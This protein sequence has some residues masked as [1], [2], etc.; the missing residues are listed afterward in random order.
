MEQDNIGGYR[1]IYFSRHFLYPPPFP[2]VGGGKLGV[3]GVVIILKAR[4]VF[5]VSK[6]QPSEQGREPRTKSGDLE[7]PVVRASASA[8]QHSAG[9][10]AGEGERAAG[11]SPGKDPLPSLGTLQA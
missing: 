10:Q 7:Q 11:E 6:A 4:L 8:P 3:E 2:L 1:L 9:L 5:C